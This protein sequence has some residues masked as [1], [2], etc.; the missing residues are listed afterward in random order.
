MEEKEEGS[1]DLPMPEEKDAGLSRRLFNQ[2]ED[3]TEL[4]LMPHDVTPELID[5]QYFTPKLA[6]SF[7]QQ[8]CQCTCERKD[9]PK[10]VCTEPPRE[11]RVSFNEDEEKIKRVPLPGGGERIIRRRKRKSYDQLNFLLEVY[12]K[13]PDWTKEVMQ[14]VAN[15]TGLSE[16]QVYKW[17]WDQ[18]RKQ[19]E[20]EGI[21]LEPPVPMR[22]ELGVRRK[23]KAIAKA[24]L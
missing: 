19:M 11:R 22:Q 6:E 3:F 4:E 1:D 24:S 15:K 17:G 20:E 8:R 2:R 18:K 7:K 21:E 9:R 10:T 23:A 14:E 12:N 5:S 16:A 13:H